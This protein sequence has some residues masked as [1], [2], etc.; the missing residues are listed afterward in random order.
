MNNT[1]QT[2]I[3]SVW[4]N[5]A[6]SFASLTTH[7][8]ANLYRD[9]ATLLHGAV[10]DFGCGPAKLA[11]YLIGQPAITRYLGVDASPKMVE[12]GRTALAMLADTR[13]EIVL[14]RIEALVHTGFNCGISINS[15]YAWSEPEAVLRHIGACLAPD[16]DFILATPN[17]SLSMPALLEECGKDLLLG[18]HFSEF[19]QWNLYLSAQQVQR[20]V[21][22]DELIDQLRGA[23]FRIN[24]CSQEYFA[25]GLNFV[26]AT[27]RASAQ[28]IGRSTGEVRGSGCMPTNSGEFC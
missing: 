19:K 27:K 16:A 10:V 1:E 20:F 15:Y 2:E 18:Q 9:V 17:A 5:Y 8:Q 4:E 3:E 23:G 26:H 21:A 22:M 11:P 13:F 12:L 25:G 14:G 6:A 24:E 28:R 7:Y